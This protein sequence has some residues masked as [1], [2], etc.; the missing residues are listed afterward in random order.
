VSVTRTRLG[1][2]L[3]GPSLIPASDLELC[4]LSY[5]NCLSHGATRGNEH[6]LHTIG[7]FFLE[8]MFTD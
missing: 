8:S 5:P 6:S 1:S 7:T 2:V 3:S 4:Q